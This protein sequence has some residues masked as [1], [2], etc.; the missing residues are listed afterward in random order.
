MFPPADQLWA[1]AHVHVNRICGERRPRS[2]RPTWPRCCRKLDNAL[3]RTRTSP[4]RA[5]CA[6]ASSS[7]TRRITPS[8]FRRSRPG[9]CAGLGLAVDSR[10]SR[11]SPRGA[12]APARPE[13]VSVL[14]PLVLPHGHPRRLR[15]SR[16]PAQGEARRRARRPARHGRA[17][18]R[19]EHSRASIRCRTL[20]GI[21]RL[22]GA[23]RVPEEADRGHRGIRQVRELGGRRLPAADP[24]GD[25][26][27]P[28]SRGRLP[29]AQARIRSRF[30]TRTIRSIPIR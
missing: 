22:G 26:G 25:R 14:P 30:P 21:L 28:E 5:C 11:R 15:V 20:G 3:T 8:S 4:T 24:E 17:G 10:D 23:L 7:R 9:A 13:R 19:L 2:S 12:Y 16:A 18:A 6:R 1:W 27:F 29:E